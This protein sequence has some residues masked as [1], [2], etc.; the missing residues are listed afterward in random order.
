M[1]G[2]GIH[3]AKKV[4][5]TEMP[6]PGGT[7]Y[8]FRVWLLHLLVTNSYIDAP[9]AATHAEH[10]IHLAEVFLACLSVRLRSLALLLR[11][12]SFVA[13]FSSS[14]LNIPHKLHK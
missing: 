6:E 4:E 8:S 10:V 2:I 7:L 9:E 13:R 14:A 5:M 12:V 3:Y 1:A 11:L